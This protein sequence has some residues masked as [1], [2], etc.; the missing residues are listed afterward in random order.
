MTESNWS[1][2]TSQV[3]R[4]AREI[5]DSDD[6]GILATITAVEGS[7]YRRP[8]AKMIIPE[9]GS[10]VG[11]ITAGCLED[12]VVR[13]ADEVLATGEPRIETYD[14]RPEAEEDVWGL[15][16]GCNGI[17]DILLEP[18][19]DSFRP[20]V[21]AREAGRAIALATVIDGDDRVDVGARARFDPEADRWSEEGRVP[22]S[23]LE[24]LADV[25]TT[26]AADGRADVVE[27]D[28]VTVFVDGITPPDHLVVVG[29]GHDIGPIVELGKRADFR[30][31][32]VG[33]RGA[34]ARNDRFPD[35][36][37]VISTSPVN[38]REVVAT[39]A[40]TYVVVAT[41]NFIDDRLTVEELLDTDVP[42][43]GLMGPRERFEEMMADF[44]EEGRSVS[45]E[46]RSRLYTPVGID[47]GGGS[48]HQIAISIVAEVLAVA[49]DRTPRHL[50][51]RDGPIHDR[52]TLSTD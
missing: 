44:T 50:K 19:D 8:G 45:G 30:V 3:F 46:E 9:A 41:H 18:L 33:Y 40:D 34:S 37:A 5:I 12:E 29:T 47:L 43:I 52:L 28:G 23:V 32:V 6:A 16:V 15:G 26:V 14:L 24:R 2:S 7:A 49:N 11:H 22:R 51:E 4:H 38:I 13:L 1:V 35:A 21:E 25:A 39:D 36:D 42:Y 27:A 20:A 10:G 48:P 31:T 17:I